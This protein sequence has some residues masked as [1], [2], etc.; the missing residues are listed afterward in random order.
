MPAT[1]GQKNKVE[2][3]LREFKD[4]ELHSSSGKIV[5]S[6]K[7]A[8]AVALSESGQSDRQSSKRNRKKK[9]DAA[10]AHAPK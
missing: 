10:H 5:T 4:G 6:R 9:R 3:V 7:Q 8:I 1:R 2:T